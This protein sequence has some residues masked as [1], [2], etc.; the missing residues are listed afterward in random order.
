MNVINFRTLI[1]ASIRT[2]VAAV[3]SDHW[4]TMDFNIKYQFCLN[5]AHI[6][7]QK[8]IIVLVQLIE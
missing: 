5:N 4:E 8:M 2:S 1:K 6:Q 7:F 3:Y